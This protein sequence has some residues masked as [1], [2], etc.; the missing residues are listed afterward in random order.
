MEVVAERNFSCMLAAFIQN[1]PKAL[2]C[3]NDVY[4][5]DEMLGMPVVCFLLVLSHIRIMFDLSGSCLCSNDE[6]NRDV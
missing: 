4:I 2:E 3:M 1:R 5:L 6:L